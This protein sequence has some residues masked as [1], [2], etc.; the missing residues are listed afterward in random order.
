[1][2]TKRLFVAVELP[3]ELR[4]ELHKFSAALDQEGIKRVAEDNLHLTL[5][6]IGEVPITV[7][8]EIIGKLQHVEF[9]SFTATI[10]TVGAFPNINHVNIVWVGLE[11]EQMPALATAV[12]SRL[13]G[14]GKEDERPFSA[15][16]TIARLKHKMD[17]RKFIEDN[18]SKE[19]GSFTVSSFTLFESRLTPQGPVYTRVAE[20]KAQ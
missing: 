14:I 6:F 9:T 3:A 17:L 15:H 5:R 10:K 18:R 20:F 13:K 19:F 16:L 8:P 2:E 12:V 7:V 1:M 4:K 11:S